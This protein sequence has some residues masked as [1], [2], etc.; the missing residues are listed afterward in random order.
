VANGLVD[1]AVSAIVGAAKTGQVGDGKIFVS[2]LTNVVRV[3]TG[4]SGEAAI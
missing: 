1:K 3:R 2:D 4:E